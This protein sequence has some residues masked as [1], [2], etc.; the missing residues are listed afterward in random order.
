MVGT[1]LILSIFRYASSI[2]IDANK[3]QLN[4]LQTLLLKTTRPII[5]YD[6]YKLSTYQILT[7]LNWPSIHHMV[8][9]EALKI[10]HKVVFDDNPPSLSK[11]FSYSLQRSDISRL[12]RKPFM[13]Q[14]SST[15]KLSQSVLFRSI[16]IYNKLSE[17]TPKY[18]PEK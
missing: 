11:L 15:A 8:M 3:N 6:S 4:K 9:A 16:F 12:S 17:T 10:T 2:L 13:I 5:G 7:R 18:S 1:S 14:K